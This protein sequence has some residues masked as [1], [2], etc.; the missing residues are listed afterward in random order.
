MELLLNQGILLEELV[1]TTVGDVLD[2]LL[3]H[4]GG[5]SL[6]SLLHDLAA[7]LCV[8]GGDPALGDVGLDVVLA[9]EVVGVQTGLLQCNLSGLADLLLLGLL[10]GDLQLACNNVGGNVITADGN[11]IHGGYL[12]GDLLADLGGNVGQAQANDGG[13][14]VAQVLVACYAGSL[15]PGILAQ[16]HLL[17]GLTDLVSDVLGNRTAVEGQFLNLVHALGLSGQGGL[18]DLLC[19][20]AE[21]LVLG[22]EVRLALQCGDCCEVAVGAGEHATLGGVAGLTL[23]GYSLT[24]LTD[25]L[26]GSLDVAVGLGQGVLAVHHTC[27]G[28]LTQFLDIF[29]AYC[30]CV[31]SCLKCK[32]EPYRARLTVVKF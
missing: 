9:V 21:G 27:A 22:N 5:L 11:G 10:D 3:G 16:L 24:L 18:Q 8:L 28:H 23:G 31:S 32:P 1:Q 15:Q 6:S 14:L 25:D 2:H 13:Q 19:Q 4:V 20:G 30:H 17:A 7:T 26:D 29:N 12:H